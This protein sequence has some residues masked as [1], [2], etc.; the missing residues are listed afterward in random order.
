MELLSRKSSPGGSMT[1]VRDE[2]DQVF[3]ALHIASM[4]PIYRDLAT[5]YC[6]MDAKGDYITSA[7]G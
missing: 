6:F 7:R 2:S 1:W 5:R 3:S 4:A